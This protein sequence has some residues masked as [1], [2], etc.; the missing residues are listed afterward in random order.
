MGY[1]AVIFDL[2]GTILNTLED[3]KDS[4]NVSL[5]KAGFPERSLGEVRSFVGN[6][7]RKLIE[8][9]V[10]SG[11]SC[12]NTEKVYEYFTEHYMANCCNK[13]CAYEGIMSVLESLRAKGVRTA[14]L[15][16]KA[17][18]AVRVICS[19]YFDGLFDAV[20]GARDDIPKKPSPE[21]V[22][23]IMRRIGA[24]SKSTL[25]V[26]DSD[27]DFATAGNAGLRCV[28]VDWG[29]RGGEYLKSLS[30]DVQL[31]SRPEEL[32]AFI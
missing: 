29:F 25:Y 8:R 11:T 6:G 12:E 20:S 18:E 4:L 24:D 23:D 3:L 5:K 16:N 13:T 19:H 1:K 7:I 15:S 32:L 31:I 9:G 17:D 14:V 26:G 22:F 28:L 21:G 30:P 2:D 27:V 10:P